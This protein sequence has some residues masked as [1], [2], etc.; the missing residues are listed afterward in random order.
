MAEPV[1][2]AERAARSQ[3]LRRLTGIGPTVCLGLASA[4]L[5][6]A[7]AARTWAEARTREVGLQ[8]ESATGVDVAPLVLPLTLVLLAAWGTVLVLRRRGR[9][10]VAVLGLLSGV[11]AG[12]A[13]LLRAPDAAAV[14]SD[15]LG[16]AA[17]VST[18]LTWWPAVTVAGALVSG[19]AFVVVW[20]R[21]PTWPEMSGRYDAPRSAAGDQA[22]GG[23]GAVTEPRDLWKAQDAGNDPTA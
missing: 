17:D 2:P 6:T 10:A 13:A 22:P 11:T 7:A 3:R 8:V 16:N 15:M 1:G 21:A 12:L 9:R 20:L 14:A 19:A 5:A 18:S 4:A 23:G